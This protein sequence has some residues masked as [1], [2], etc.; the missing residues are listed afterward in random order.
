MMFLE[1]TDHIRY[2]AI[3]RQAVADLL[4]LYRSGTVKVFDVLLLELPNVLNVLSTIAHE[5]WFDLSVSY[6]CN[7]DI[8]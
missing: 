1:T 7:V 8:S 6:G 3:P 5:A 2:H 4:A